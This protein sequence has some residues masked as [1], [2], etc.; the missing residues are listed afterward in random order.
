MRVPDRRK[1]THISRELTQQERGRRESR[2]RRNKSKRM[3]SVA[4][5]RLKIIQRDV[6]RVAMGRLEYLANAEPRS[7]WQVFC[8]CLDHLSFG[9]VS[10]QNAPYLV[11]LYTVTRNMRVC[12]QHSAAQPGCMLAGRNRQGSVTPPSANTTY[13]HHVGNNSP[14]TR[15]LRTCRSVKELSSHAAALR[16]CWL[17]RACP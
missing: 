16:R 5:G 7:G 13:T 12:C 6:Q 14:Q 10:T 4:E 9:N 17:W 2:K 3:Y 1:T 15:K 11:P 8:C